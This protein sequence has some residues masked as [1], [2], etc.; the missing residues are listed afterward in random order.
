MQASTLCF[1]LSLA[2]PALCADKVVI[3]FYAESLCPY[4][5][6]LAKGPMNNAVKEARLD[7]VCMVCKNYV[8]VIINLS[9]DD[10]TAVTRL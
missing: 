6:D 4:C 10:A 7:Y 3:G 9:C 8:F 1:L 5:I 2:L